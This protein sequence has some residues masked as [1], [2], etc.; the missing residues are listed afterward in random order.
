M[1]RTR[2]QLTALLRKDLRIEMRTRETVA[3]TLLFAVVAMLIFQFAIAQ[4]VPT[5]EAPLFVGGFAW[6]TIALTAVLGVGRTWVPEREQRVLDGLLVAPVPRLVFLVARTIALIFY[7]ALIELLVF[8]LA[9]VFFAPDTGLGDLGLALVAALV[10]N[11]GIAVV[12][13]FLASMS[14]FSQARELLLP[15]MFLPMILPNIIA[16][17]GAA[18][19][20][21]GPQHDLADYRG[22]CLFS[23][24]YAVTFCL[25]AYAIYDYI[26]DD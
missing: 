26:L 8:P 18:Y 17:A 6:A 11:I 19:A 21:L 25:V 13:A 12:G 2:R 23:G 20:V 16:A 7:L 3:A 10:A 5:P 15:V 4:H 24:V 22:Y 9:V 1:S 14:V